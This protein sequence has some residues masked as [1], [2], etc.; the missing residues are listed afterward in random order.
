MHPVANLTPEQLREIESET[1]AS[2]AGRAEGFWEGTRD[3]DVSQNIEALLDAI[4][5]EGPH[6]ILDLGCGPGRDLMDLRRRG[7]VVRRRR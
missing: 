1:L 3:H 2:Y 6:R 4:E 7:R 5:G